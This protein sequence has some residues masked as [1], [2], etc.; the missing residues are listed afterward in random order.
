MERQNIMT[1]EGIQN[2]NNYIDHQTRL[3]IRLIPFDGNEN[4]IGGRRS[5]F[6]YQ[7]DPQKPSIVITAAHKWPEGGFF[8]E[9]RIVKEGRPLLINAGKFKVLYK[10]NDTDIAYSVLPRE[11]IAESL[12]EDNIESPI[13]LFYQHT[14]IPGNSDEDYGFAVLNNH[15]FIQNGNVLQLHVYSCFEIGMKLD[16]QDGN[17]QYLRTIAKIR[18]DDYYYGASGS[19]ITDPEGAITSILVGREGEFLKAFRLDNKLDLFANL[20]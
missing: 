13:V 4:L 17:F 3:T 15:E 2:I 8:I 7:P 5:G 14:F 19:P 16:H 9:T 18:D 20:Q 6:L 1:S 12:K 10:I 11:K